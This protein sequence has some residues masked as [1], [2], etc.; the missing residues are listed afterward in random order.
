MAQN[1]QKKPAKG[2]LKTSRSVDSQDNAMASSS[3][4]AKEQRFDEINIM[5]TFHP[6]DK[7]YGHMKVDEPKTPYSEAVDGD[8]EP[9]D[10]LDANI[11]AAKLAASMNK[12][13]KCLESSESD[14]DETEEERQRRLEFKK[15]RKIHYN[16]F[17]ALQ[18]A[19]QLMAQEEEEDEEE[20][21]GGTSAT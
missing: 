1:L 6:P 3:K 8:L 12:P 11:L 10:E 21:K 4:R 13:P 14:E 7:D 5:E 9:T 17:Q 16:E 18:L 15:K 20:E 2:I 19:R